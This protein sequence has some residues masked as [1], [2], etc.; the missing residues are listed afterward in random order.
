MFYEL[1]KI[2]KFTFSEEAQVS[3]RR[4]EDA[5]TQEKVLYNQRLEEL[6]SI[7]Q[8]ELNARDKEHSHE[9]TECK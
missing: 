9:L 1:A 2:I 3:Y 6:Q 4:L 8:N 5:L 7:Q